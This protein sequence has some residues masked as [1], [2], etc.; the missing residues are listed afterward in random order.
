MPSGLPTRVP[1]L[2]KTAALAVLVMSSACS[3]PR[4]DASAEKTTFVTNE[5]SDAAELREAAAKQDPREG[6]QRLDEDGDAFV[7]ESEFL[8]IAEVRFTRMT[9]GD[10]GDTLNLEQF[11]QGNLGRPPERL[12]ESFARKDVDADGLLSIDEY[13]GSARKSFDRID[14][15]DDGKIELEEHVAARTRE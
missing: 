3:G 12:N 8:Q 15:N 5:S 1:V 6:F 10:R 11:A 4:E 14:S 9:G 2:L 7:S 13:L